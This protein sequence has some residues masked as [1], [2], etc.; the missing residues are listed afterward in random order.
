MNP[1][2]H[3][4][5]HLVWKIASLALLLVSACRTPDYAK[6][7]SP[8]P[9]VQGLPHPA[10]FYDPALTNESL[11]KASPQ[12]FDREESEIHSRCERALELHLERVFSGDEVGE[13][14]TVRFR[15]DSVIPQLGS[16]DCWL[17][18]SR[19]PR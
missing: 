2:L 10:L 8:S 12:P 18:C 6:F 5:N 16:S 4:S 19:S 9:A 17:P 14:A 15:V 3:R 1:D 13:V 11:Q 7:W